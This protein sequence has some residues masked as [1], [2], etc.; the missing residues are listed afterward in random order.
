V[1]VL[2]LWLYLSSLSVLIGGELNAELERQASK[3]DG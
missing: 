2:I 3:E 1:I